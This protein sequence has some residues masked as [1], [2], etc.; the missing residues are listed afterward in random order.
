MELLQVMHDMLEK[1][2]MPA[3]EERTAGEKGLQQLQTRAGFVPALFTV[4]GTPVVRLQVRQAA[5]LYCKN[6]IRSSW[7][8]SARGNHR[9]TLEGIQSLDLDC[10]NRL[11]EPEEADGEE[12]EAMSEAA[13]S[14][15]QGGGGRGGGGGGAGG[16]GR[17]G[18]V[19]S[20][21]SAYI[22][23]ED[24]SFV[25]EMLVP[26]YLAAAAIEPLR[27][28]VG[29]CVRLIAEKDFP[30]HTPTL[31][32]AIVER[33]H[34]ETHPLPEVVSALLL[35][36]EVSR[37]FEQD[38]EKAPALETFFDTLLQ[39]L[40]AV[41]LAAL[42][43][44]LTHAASSLVTKVIC[45]ILWSSTALAFDHGYGLPPALLREQVVEQLLEYLLRVSRRGVPPEVG[46][47][48]EEEGK[49]FWGPQKWSLRLWM[50]LLSRYGTPY[51]HPSGAPDIFGKGGGKSDDVRISALSL[52]RTVLDKKYVPAVLHQTL[53][54]LDATFQGR[55]IPAKIHSE[56]MEF[57]ADCVGI[58]QTWAALRKQL[59]PLFYHVLLPA[60]WHNAHDQALWNEDPVEYILAKYDTDET[61]KHVCTPTKLNSPKLN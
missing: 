20:C 42:E 22:P 3:S 58:P 9:A 34:L 40:L 31:L 8:G 46:G 27:K 18:S 39:P 36:R 49:V 45:K 57:V 50:R 53:L 37:V 16:G 33:L 21:T 4:V 59:Q 43:A 47:M 7:R 44:P 54:I 35:L 60:L 23:E 24:R 28:P 30:E 11:I 14:V 17:G 26:A 13:S 61:G 19:G 29:E 51:G 41:G 48:S 15:D 1:T 52:H 2:L 38:M 10:D 5:A 6:F 55:Q 12:E 32:P 56:L 25:R